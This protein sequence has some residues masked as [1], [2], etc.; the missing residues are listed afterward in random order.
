[1]IDLTFNFK[2]LDSSPTFPK[3]LKI[4][5]TTIPTTTTQL[6]TTLFDQQ[7]YY[8]WLL[9]TIIVIL[10][11]LLILMSIFLCKPYKKQEHMYEHPIL[12]YVYIEKNFYV[13]CFLT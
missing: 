10:L 9:L 7:S 5:T 4:Q 13:K 8:H 3:I 11:F 2:L 6:T 12:P 1:M